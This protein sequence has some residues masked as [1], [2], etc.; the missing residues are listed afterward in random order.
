MTPPGRARARARCAARAR[1]RGRPA[2]PRGAAAKKSAASWASASSDSQRSLRLAPAARRL[3][4]QP[5]PGQHRPDR[6]RRILAGRDR[7]GRHPQQVHRLPDLGPVEEPLRARAAGTGPRP[8]PAPPRSRLVIALVLT[9][10]ASCLAGRPRADQL[11]GLARDL[12]RLGLLVGVLGQLRRR[13]GGPLRDQRLPRRRED[14]V[15][16]RHHLRCRA[17]VADQPDHRRAGVLQRE[18]GQVGGR[19]AGERVDRLPRVADHADVVAVAGPLVEQQLLQRVDV[20][21]LVDHE[22]AV[23]VPDRGG[24]DRDARPGWPR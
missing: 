3:P 5:E 4:A 1:R 8:P 13:T 9:S 12:G 15:G 21:V 10:T 7:P 17:V 11:G 2:T 22:V 18:P 14:P 20:L 19:G 6:G 23:P 16:Q 24:G